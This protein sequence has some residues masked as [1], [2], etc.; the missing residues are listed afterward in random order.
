MQ[1]WSYSAALWLYETR[2]QRVEV[3]GYNSQS[4]RRIVG[5]YVNVLV[6]VRITLSVLHL[7]SSTAFNPNPSPTP[8]PTQAHTRSVV[9]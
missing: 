2:R 7:K 4:L 8:G 3:I 1:A 5:L 9:I 6:H